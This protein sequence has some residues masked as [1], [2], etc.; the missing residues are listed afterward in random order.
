LNGGGISTFR[1]PAS[2]GSASHWSGAPAFRHEQALGTN[3]AFRSNWSHNFDRWHSGEFGHRGGEEWREHFGRYGGFGFGPYW[4]FGGYQFL[5]FSYL[6]YF[7][8]GGWGYPS[9]GYYDY[10]SPYDYGVGGGLPYDYSAPVASY[11]PT[12]YGMTGDLQAT[13]PIPS[14]DQGAVT[15]EEGSYLADALGAFHRGDY[16]EAIRLDEHAAVDTPRDA[17]VHRLMSQALFALG[18]YP[19]AAI[20]SH[21]AL[22]LGPAIDWDAL[23]GYYGDVSN[24]TTQLRALEKYS[25]DHPKAAD[26]AFLLGYQY[27]MLGYPQQARDQ[28]A[29]ALKLVPADKLAAKM[30]ADLGGK[31]AAKVPSAPAKKLR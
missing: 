18:V 2:V 16:H 26:A 9:G 19:A 20:E 12:S 1:S 7:G 30:F 29:V 6:P 8:Y 28:Y 31:T 17:K 10:G 27:Q 23:Q 25:G 11:A 4:G 3:Q 21:A 24:Y 22:A 14:A 13:E 5:D 15:E